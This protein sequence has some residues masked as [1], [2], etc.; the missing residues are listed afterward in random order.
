MKKAFA[1]GLILLAV[2]AT[3]CTRNYY[4]IQLIPR[5]DALE[6]E[7]TFYRANGTDTN[8]VPVYQKFSED[9][10]AAITKLY[11]PDSRQVDGQRHVVRGQFGG[12]MPPDIGGAGNWT[13][14][15]TSLGTAAIYVERF[16]GDDDFA[17]T[18]ERR[19]AAAEQMTDL[20]IG[21][22]RTELGQEPRYEILHRF[23]DTDFRR[24]LKNLI[25]Y[26]WVREISAKSDPKRNEEIVIRFAQ[27]LM[28]RGYFKLS[29]LP[30]FFA[31]LIKNDDRAITRLIQRLVA[32]KMGFSE[33][34]PLPE[35][36]VFLSDPAAVSA[37][38]EKYLLTTEAYQVHVQKWE[39]ERKLNP[40]LEKP[41][42]TDVTQE[43]FLAA[44]DSQ[45]YGTS[46]QLK[47]KLALSAA[48][49]RTNGKWD[50][51]A[52]QVVWEF[53]LDGAEKPTGLP[54]FCYASW[55][56]AN[57]TFQQEHLGKVLLEGEPLLQYC[58][59]LASLNA[60][61]TGE[62]EAFLAGLKP[63][64]TIVAALDTFRFSDE[65]AA[66]KS[67]PDDKTHLASEI[68]RELLK[69]ALTKSLPAPAK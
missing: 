2:L 36:L 46:D 17:T 28:E 6:R 9:Q 58:L 10:F 8:G 59:G 35:C 1:P 15:T 34:D 38:W 44:L 55:S 47:V 26:N 61:H 45:L 48:P 49:I 16:R 67:K 32:T 56:T 43:L 41:K 31:A 13:N 20:L 66:T 30:D 62:W 63:D 50:A 18:T 60:K 5:G 54:A 65:P 52:S 23:L 57:E 14:Y 51:A 39:Q 25:L 19:L 24:D 29:E 4:E 40:D 68:P 53:D 22:S 11:P 21:W 7:L 33:S 69:A 3:G 64:A 37:S 27:Y 12:T 42:P